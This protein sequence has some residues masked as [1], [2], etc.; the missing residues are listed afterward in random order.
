MPVEA[1]IAFE[2]L[3]THLEVGEAISDPAT[4][5]YRVALPYGVNYGLH[6]K[7]KGYISVNENLELVDVRTYTE[8][9]KDLY[10]VPIEVG[11]A[12]Q[13]NNVFFE[14]GRPLLKPESYP[15]LDRLVQVL[16]ENPTIEIELSGHTDNVGNPA[17][18]LS[19]SQERVATVKDYLVKN[20]IHGSRITGRGYG[21][22]RP[23]VKNDTEANRRMNRR[24]EFK[25][26]KK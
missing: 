19:L 25:I 8:L 24:V 5:E 2:N 13:L 3:A 11:E 12:I 9:Q 1:G 14:Q 17:A 26:T 21:A 7:A 6:A 22:T 10:L 15:E 20:G 16:K 4:G 23:L 18:L